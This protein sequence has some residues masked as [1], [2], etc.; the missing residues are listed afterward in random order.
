[1]TIPVWIYN[2]LPLALRHYEDALLDV[3]ATCGIEAR[4]VRAPSLEV[5]GAS[6]VRRLQSALVEL[7]ARSRA[8]RRGG[9]L[10]VCWPS[11]G[12]LDPALW[13]SGWG[14]T[15]VSVVVHDPTPL[16]R[17]LL[18]GPVAASF[19]GRASR[20]RH[21]RVVVHSVP[22]REVLDAIGWP[23]PTLLPHP[24]WRS[25]V[26][27]EESLG[28][29][30]VLVC[31][32]YKPARDIGLLR[33]LGQSLRQRGYQTVIAGR[34]WPSVPGWEIH[35]GFLTEEEL[36]RTI[37]ASAAVLIPYSRFYQSGIAVRA[38]E[39]GIPVVGADHPFLA[40][41]LGADWPGLVR[42]DDPSNWADAV[43]KVA[44]ESSLMTAA[45]TSSRQRC[46]DQWQRYLAT[47]SPVRTQT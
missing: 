20:A 2:P 43:G 8:A 45:A 44:G 22:A 26:S 30:Q 42:A 40:D 11:Y 47:D 37:S 27:V 19:G 12:L 21:I 38:V 33:A 41:L 4:S 46:E 1:M 39:R 14:R 13:M 36:D 3:L 23:A 6:L 16:R 18:M 29:R 5:A 25:R 15:T 17:Q 35:D 31:G 10:V 32:Q 24:L 7:A 28:S 9:H 34:G